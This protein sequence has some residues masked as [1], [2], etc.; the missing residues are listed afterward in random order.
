[1][2][3]YSFVDDWDLP[4]PLG[5]MWKC[6]GQEDIAR[7]SAIEPKRRDSQHGNV[8]L[9]R[10]R[11][12]HAAFVRPHPGG[13]HGYGAIGEADQASRRRGVPAARDCDRPAGAGAG[14]YRGG[15][16]TEPDHSVV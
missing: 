6:S 1:M 14:P 11:P 13:R 7:I 3:S 10:D 12:A 4:T 5:V 2:A 8:G 15:F 16:G 9:D